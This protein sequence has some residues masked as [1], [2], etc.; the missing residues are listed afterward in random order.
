MNKKLAKIYYA[1]LWGLREEKYEHLLMS[2]IQTS[3]WKKLKPSPPYYFFV[4]KDF[5]LQ[6]E[7]KKFWKVTDIFKEFSTGI[8]TH[9]DHFRSWTYKR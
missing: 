3:R 8:K 2:D 1:D 5:A 4:P 9:R 7:Y 6:A